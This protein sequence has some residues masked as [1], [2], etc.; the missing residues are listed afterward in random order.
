M[1]R[2]SALSH[3]QQGLLFTG[4][5]ALIMAPDA[6]LIKVAD[7][8]DAEILMWRGFL[9]ALGFL[10]IALLRYGRG[11][12]AAYR[13]CGWTGIAVALLFSLTTCGFV[14]GNQYTKA[15][16]V[17]MILASSPLIAAVLSWIILKERLPRRTWLAIW[18]CMVGIAMIALDDADAGSWIGNAF[19]LMA[20]TTLA[21]NF[22]LCRTRPGIDMS[23]M[24]VFNGIIIG[25]VAGL[26]WLAGNEPALPERS[27][28]AVVVLLCLV[29]VPCGVTLLQRGPLYLPAAEVGL[30][31]LLEVV[32]GTLLAWWVLGEKPASVALL[33]GGLVLGTLLAKSLYERRLEMR[34]RAGLEPD[35]PITADRSGTV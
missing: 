15:G 7:L 18:L 3:R 22:T 1:N 13:R 6:L 8:P 27:Q 21:I 30:L 10:L 29:I 19:A 31:L 16:N 11:T 4:G 12:L 20:A 14:L 28:L 34:Q 24:L 32:L 2:L 35:P 33:G 9:S 26:F 5:G 17:L 23:P 25:S